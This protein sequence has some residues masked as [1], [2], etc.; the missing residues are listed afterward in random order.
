MIDPDRAIHHR[1]R[2]LEGQI[3]GLGRMFEAGR[4]PAELLDQIAAIRAALTALGLA[5]IARELEAHVD[6]L[7][8]GRGAP[9][10]LDD[11]PCAL[12]RRLIRST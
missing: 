2:R 1:L 9:A 4:P 11:D 5:V 3:A 8:N 10:H 7:R 12:T 6:G